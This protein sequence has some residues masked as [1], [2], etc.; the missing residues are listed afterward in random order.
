MLSD[1]ERATRNATGAQRGC[2]ACPVCGDSVLWK[3]FH[4]TVHSV[5]RHVGG[6]FE[7][8]VALR[9]LCE[10]CWAKL[11]PAERLPHHLALMSHQVRSVRKHMVYQPVEVEVEEP[12][13]VEPG[14]IPA[15]PP[16]MVK[17]KVIVRQQMFVDDEGDRPRYERDVAAAKAATE[18]IQQAIMAGK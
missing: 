13:A 2:Y 3:P 8:E 7:G 4:S 9:A 6:S 5:G 17:R 10:E 18:A 14:A 16:K 12:E 1:T 15:D 11:T